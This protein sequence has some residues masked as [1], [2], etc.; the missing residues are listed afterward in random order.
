MA[1][2]K[3]VDSTRLDTDLTSIA[4]AIRANNGTSASLAF[5]QDFI[6]SINNMRPRGE[7]VVFYDYDGTIVDSYTA[8]D[9]AKLTELPPAPDHSNDEVP[10]T[11]QGW[12]WSLADAKAYVAQYG[13]LNVGQM[14]ATTDEKTHI[15][16]HLQEECTSPILGCCPNGTVDVDWGDGTAHDTLT[17]TSVS[18]VVYTNRHN[19]AQPGDYEIILTCTGTMGFYGNP[20]SN[21]SG[22]LQHA[23]SYNAVNRV[24]QASIRKIYCANNVADIKQSALSGLRHLLSITIPNSVISIGNSAFAGCISLPSVT[25]PNSVKSISNSTFSTCRGLAF[26]SIPKSVTNV[27][28]GAFQNC[29]T[30]TSITLPDSFATL[31]ENCFNGCYSLSSITIPNTIK[32]IGDSA[33]NSCY[34]LISVNI[35]SGVTSMGSNVFQNCYS[36]RPVTIPSGVTSIPSRTFSNSYTLITITM[37][38]GITSIRSNAFTGCSNLLFITIPSSVTSIE[39]DAFLNCYSLSSITIPERVTSIEANAFKGC[40]GMRVYHVLPMTPPTLGNANAFEGIP[41]DCIIYVPRGSLNAYKTA[42][43]WSTYAS[44]MQEEP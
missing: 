21:Y 31:R 41:G 40:G 25:I 37:H 34:A 5:P 17:G 18:T 9:F 15:F 30:L 33:F 11:S 28:T 19:Y 32:T 36:L 6:Y 27:G 12:N 1:V 3:L 13:K 16:I 44:R 39:G 7:D 35:P 4:D 29:S 38:N 2:D 23:Y 22:L 43:N 8:T 42:T 14:Y 20:T 26:I 10:L 24:Y